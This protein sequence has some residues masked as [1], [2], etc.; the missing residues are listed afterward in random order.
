VRGKL[1]C[2]AVFEDGNLAVAVLFVAGFLAG[3]DGKD[4]VDEFGNEFLHGAAF[5]ELS[6]REINPVGLVLGE[7][8]IGGDLHGGHKG[9]EG[10]A[11]TGGEEYDMA[12]AGGEGRRGYEV[13]A[14][15]GEQVETIGREA[16]AILHNTAD[17]CLAA[18][19][20]AAEGFILEGGD[21]AGLVA[22]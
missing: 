9:A 3:G 1:E 18:L 20:G 5:D 22:G 16:V 4:L 17:G 14:G 10:R 12:T 13:V 11:A 2:D 6:G 19:L 21:A 15:G 8:G 7:H